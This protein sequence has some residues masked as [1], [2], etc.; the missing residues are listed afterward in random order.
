M[1][2]KLRDP[3]DQDKLSQLLPLTNVVFQL[4]ESGREYVEELKHISQL[5]GRIVSQIEANQRGLIV[6]TSSGADV[7][8]N[9]DDPRRK[10]RCE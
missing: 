4:H 3:V 1:R 8:R 7:G 6:L 2:P 9:A 5:L 10:W